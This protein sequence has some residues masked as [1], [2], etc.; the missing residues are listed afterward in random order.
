M[1]RIQ[2]LHNESLIIDGH[3]DILMDVEIQRA[4]GRRKVIETDYVNDFKDG[5]I[6]LIVASLFIDS[7]FLPEMGTRKA[8]AQVTALYEEVDESSDLIMICKNYEDILKAKRENKIGF[9]LSLEGVEPIGNDLRLLRIFYELGVRIVG[10]VWSRRNYAADGSHFS[11]VKEGKK[12]G[13]SEFGVQLIEAAEALGMFIDVSHLNDE[14]FWDV[15]A[16]AKKPVIASHSNARAVTQTM[17]NLT[18]DQIKAIAKKGGVIG[19]NAAN[20]F[21]ADKPED[22]DI[23]HL[24]D[25]LD[26]I[27]QL[28]GVEHVGIGLD[29]CDAFMKY[30]S[31]DELARMKEKPFDVVKGHKEMKKVTRVLIQRGYSDEDI[32]LILGKNYLRVYKGV[33]K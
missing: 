19:M 33:F 8:L 27:V 9:L 2:H 15:M 20:M 4:K 6:N 17:R 25:H 14:G 28:V 13:L 7:E 23:E 26:H 24:I 3:F 18:D 5:G 1:E 16:F 29:L 21:V 11:P 31:P 22:G 30:I 12:G 10:L 32:A